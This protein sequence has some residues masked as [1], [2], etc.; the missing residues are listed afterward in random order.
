[1]S[2][3]YHKRSSTHG[4]DILSPAASEKTQLPSIERTKKLFYPHFHENSEE[5]K[6]LGTLHKVNR[7]IEYYPMENIN[8]DKPK[9]IEI[10]GT[11]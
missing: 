1:M 7:K 3:G 10:Q 4:V 8:Y 5:F 11:P 9:L 6:D 2:P